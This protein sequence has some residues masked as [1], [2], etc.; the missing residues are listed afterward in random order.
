MSIK[1]LFLA[2]AFTFLAGRSAFAQTYSDPVAY[3]HAV[4]RIDKP[5][6]RYTGP[7]LPAWMAKKLNLK[8]S[9]SRMME[10]R[11][12]DGTVLACLYGAN[13]PCDSKA[14]TSQKPTDPILDYCRQNPDSTFV[15][16]V[17]TGHDTTVSWACHGGNPVVINSAA[18]DAQGYA[19]AYW[20]TV[21]P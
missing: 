4:G 1:W 13:I 18:V 16:M 11:C 12:A 10:W 8:T 14:N 19:K 15:P 20:K 2:A 21:S 17:V 3:C 5:D 6:S 7:K 9:Q